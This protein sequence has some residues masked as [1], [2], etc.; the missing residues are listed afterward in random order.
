MS[1]LDFAVNSL[2]DALGVPAGK[3]YLGDGSYLLP[4]DD[5]DGPGAALL[6]QN[7]VMYI[8]DEF[9]TVGH[10]ILDQSAPIPYAENPRI[11]EANYLIEVERRNGTLYIV[12]LS[13]QAQRQ[14]GGQTLSEKRVES[15]G[16]FTS[17]KQI[18]ILRWTVSEDNVIQ[19][20][21]IFG[22]ED[23]TS[24]AARAVSQ[25]SYDLDTL[26]AALPTG[27]HQL[28]IPYI[29]P[30]TGALALLTNTAVT[31]IKPLPARDEFDLG[32][33]MTLFEALPLGA[34]ASFPIY[35]YC[36][37]ALTEDDAYRNYDLR[38]LVQPPARAV[39]PLLTTT[40]NTVTTLLSVPV[41]EARAVT[42]SGYVTGVQADGGAAIGGSY[43]VTARRATGG[44]VTIVGTASISMQED[45]GG[46]TPAVTI[47]ADTATQTVRVRVQGDG[48]WY[49]R[50]DDQR[51]TVGG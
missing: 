29:D 34:M 23:P 30:D 47:D 15:I 44:D 41:A 14:M 2:A 9:G 6:R 1:Y 33:I 11:A 27:Y 26:I 7:R 38:P 50:C 36:D 51:V 31:A 12:R 16:A 18:D 46:G 40:D 17:R 10:A 13:V 42:I 4:R 20:S 39:S 28:A 48:T 32:A 37:Q 25:P 8:R 21:D 19:M 43:L 3:Y 24:G 5:R 35:L 22:F 45:H 49:W